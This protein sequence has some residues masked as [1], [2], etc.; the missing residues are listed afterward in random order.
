MPIKKRKTA[1]KLPKTIFGKDIK[2][3]SKLKKKGS[4]RSALYFTKISDLASLMYSKGP[5]KASKDSSV[6]EPSLPKATPYPSDAAMD[7]EKYNYTVTES[8]L[9][10]PIEGG[11][12]DQ[13]LSK[14]WSDPESDLTKPILSP[15]KSLPD[16]SEKTKIK[17]SKKREI[18]QDTVLKYRY[19]WI[20]GR[21]RQIFHIPRG[22]TPV[23]CVAVEQ[24]SHIIRKM[25]KSGKLSVK[26][27][28]KP[29]NECK[30]LMYRYQYD[31]KQR[32]DVEC[33][34]DSMAVL[35]L[36]QVKL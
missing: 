12:L 36:S 21:E 5:L 19:R 16:S 31:S 8:G 13:R 4:I 14:N 6:S 30:Q 20:P 2:F 34:I 35:K 24:F 28:N 27:T 10:C 11:I 29:R 17:G 33:L 23:Q 7:L 22:L 1:A 32:K 3:K 15:V 25:P 26:M 9:I 18:Y